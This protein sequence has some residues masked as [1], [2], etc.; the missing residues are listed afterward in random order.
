MTNFLAIQNT[1][2]AIDIALFNDQQLVSSV[3]ED[4]VNASKQF[5]PLLDRLL[6]KNN[7][8]IKDLSFIA[9]NQGPG[10]FTTLRVIIASANGLNF[11][12]KIPL[13]GIDAFDA[14]FEEYRDHSYPYTVILLNAFHHD[15]YFAVYQSDQAA[16]SKGYNNIN[17]FLQELKQQIPHQIIRFLGNATELYRNELQATFGDQLYIPEQLPHTCS[18]PYVG[19][20]GLKKWHKKEGLSEQLL[21]LYLKRPLVH[22]QH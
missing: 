15:V 3:S 4:K 5:I 1:Y 22:K 10:P 17:L 14:L 19:Q 16:I 6:E 11:A 12:T 18:I 9:V 2:L 21:P 20:I 13:I 8:H 7:L